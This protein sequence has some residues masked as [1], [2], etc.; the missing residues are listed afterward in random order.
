MLRH[1]SLFITKVLSQIPFIHVKI[2]KDNVCVRMY[3]Q[4]STSHY[5]ILFQY[6]TIY[7]DA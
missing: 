2:P 6:V 3:V 4:L 1:K 7:I 5:N